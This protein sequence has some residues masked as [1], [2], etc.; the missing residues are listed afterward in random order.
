MQQILIS[1][2][3]ARPL[4]PNFSFMQMHIS[5]SLLTVK[6]LI[7][8]MHTAAFFLTAPQVS[9]IQPCFIPFQPQCP[10]H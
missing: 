7:T 10:S 8:G 3:V 1:K 6:Q 9:E 5:V 4:E 2:V